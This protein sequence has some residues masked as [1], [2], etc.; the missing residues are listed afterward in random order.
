[1]GKI[2]KCL[3]VKILSTAILPRVEGRTRRTAI[4]RRKMKIIERGLKDVSSDGVIIFNLKK[5]RFL[6]SNHIST[7]C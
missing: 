2:V 7:F 5:E 4:D 1:M 3:S 6:K